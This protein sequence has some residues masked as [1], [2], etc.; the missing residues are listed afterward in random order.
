MKKC[1]RI[2]KQRNERGRKG[3]SN[4]QKAI[5]REGFKAGLEFV[6]DTFKNSN[7]GEQIEIILKELLSTIEE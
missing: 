3:Y 6:I 4:I 2:L 1:E 7:R 5:F